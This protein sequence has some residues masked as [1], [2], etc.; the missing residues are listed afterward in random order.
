MVGMLEQMVP[1]IEIRSVATRPCMTAYTA[2]GAP[3]IDRLSDRVGVAVGGN[4]WGI[5]TSEEI[6][7]LAAAMS[8]GQE[9]GAEY[10]AGTFRAIFA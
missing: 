7:R 2:S 1:A 5:M 9:F 10:G 8:R 6:G 4:A 3:Y